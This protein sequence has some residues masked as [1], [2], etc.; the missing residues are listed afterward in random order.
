MPPTDKPVTAPKKTHLEV[1]ADRFAHLLGEPLVA[2]MRAHGKPADAPAASNPIDVLRAGY[3]TALAALE[4]AVVAKIVSA[5]AAHAN[6]LQ[7]VQW[8]VPLAPASA[9]PAAK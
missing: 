5:K 7:I 1:V 3:F 9:K 8:L 2:L 4:A 6:Q